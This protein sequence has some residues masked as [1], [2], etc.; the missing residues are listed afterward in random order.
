MVRPS[1]HCHLERQAD[2]DRRLAEA[3]ERAFER[4]PSLPTHRRRAVQRLLD[5]AARVFAERGSTPRRR[6]LARATGM[7]PGGDVLLRRSKDDLLH[8]IQE[9]CFE[10]VDRGARE[11]IAAE[12]DPAERLRT[13]IRHH[14][15]FFAGH[16]A[17]MKV[18]SHE[19]GSL[20]G[21]PA[22]ALRAKKKAYSALLVELVGA[23][24]PGATAEQRAVTAYEI[25][26]MM[27]WIY[28]WYRPPVPSRRSARDPS[29][30]GGAARDPDARRSGR[31]TLSL[32]GTRMTQPKAAKPFDPAEQDLIARIAQGF[33][34]E[35][36]EDMTPGYQKALLTQLTVQ[37]DTE[38]LSAPAYYLASRDAPTLNSRIAVT[39]IIHD[40]LGHANIAY[41][42]ME[43]LG[44][45]K[46]WLLYER[47][48]HEFKHPY[49]F[50]QPLENWAEMVV[51][52]GFFDRAGITLLSDVHQHTSYGPLK[53]ALV[54]VDREEVLH[55]RHGESWMKRLAKAGGEA[56]AA[57][58]RAVDWMFP[59]TLE[60]FGLP[61]TLKHHG[62]Q[63]AYR[64]GAR[65]T[66]S[67]ARCGRRTR[68]R[69]KG[70]IRCPPTST[71]AGNT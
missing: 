46:Q 55:L 4:I 51:A 31:V 6:D 35:S 20:T 45:D 23:L 18:L 16:M 69:H 62:G 32:E 30:R 37:G 50:D 3:S 48:P 42:I 29:R 15:T 10:R 17:E 14:V 63:L 39:A 54:K 1:A 2:R 61:D 25:F 49:G 57:L 70:S 22:R 21:P 60:W 26:V 58:Q 71:R 13:F 68:C 41:R 53:R 43:D 38:L 56:R 8:L 34:V 65:P 33:M 27:N 47:E 19:D 67:F 64:P 11:A 7:K 40:E 44:V 52:N 66:I 28:T 24:D 5:A 9:R 59:M 12:V 36:E